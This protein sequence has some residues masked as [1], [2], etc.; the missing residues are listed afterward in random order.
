MNCKNCH[1]SFP[2]DT[3]YCPS[4][5]G[6]VIRNRLTLKALFAHFS[7]QFLNYDN[8]FLKTFLHLFS[9]SEVVIDGYINGTRKR[10]VN[11]ISYFAIALTMSGLN[12]FILQK[13]FPETL[14]F[15]ALGINNQEENFQN[16]MNLV[17]EYYSLQMMLIIPL[18]ALISKIVFF[19]RKKYNYTEH[20]VIYLYTFAQT[21][22]IGVLLTFLI[23]L[24]NL[25]YGIFSYISMVITFIYSAYCLKRLYKLDLSELILKTFL[26]IFV[27]MTIYIISV[28]IFAVAFYLI[29]PEGL[30]E[31][32]R[33]FAPQKK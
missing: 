8:K 24:F 5:G 11:A 3:D 12:I 31:F 22:F 19:N 14:N 17:F 33:T 1:T 6:K 20:L 30:K 29:D 28:I 2:E 21:T 26:F 4:C 23:I 32:G 15:S 25:D 27:F 16:Y 18:I 7:E 13:F 9:K 10:Y